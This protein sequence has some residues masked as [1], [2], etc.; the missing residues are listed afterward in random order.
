MDAKRNIVERIRRAVRAEYGAP[1]RVKY[2]RRSDVWQLWI[3]NRVEDEKFT[4]GLLA[5]TWGVQL[6]SGEEAAAS[7]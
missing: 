2:D 6:R 4:L 7:H 1:V 5:T 3:G